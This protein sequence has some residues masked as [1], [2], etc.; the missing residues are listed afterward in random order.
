MAMARQLQAA[1]GPGPGLT[2]TDG[3]LEKALRGTWPIRCLRDRESSL[4]EN[5]RP[6]F[7]AGSQVRRPP[8]LPSKP[9]ESLE[10]V[11]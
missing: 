4:E 6:A 2:E 7:N 10:T 11:K 3:E 8:R 5:H 1:Q 9:L